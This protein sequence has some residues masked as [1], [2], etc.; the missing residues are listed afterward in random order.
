MVAH[1]GYFPVTASLATL[2]LGLRKNTYSMST[3]VAPSFATIK[4]ENHERRFYR[5]ELD[6]L[7]FFAFFGVFLF[8]ALPRVTSFY[9]GNGIPRWITATVIPVFTSGAYGVDLFFA[10]SAYLI[11]SLLLREHA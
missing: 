4:A 1:W 8:H 10:L 5:P 7:R 6:A 11:T 3:A 2:T 9:D